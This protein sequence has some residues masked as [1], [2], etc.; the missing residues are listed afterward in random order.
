MGLV[1]RQD[2]TVSVEPSR[3]SPAESAERSAPRPPAGSTATPE[4]LEPTEGISQFIRKVLDQL[5]LSAWLPA[6]MFVGCGALLVQL[7][8]QR[9]LDISAA[10]RALTN[11]PLG[12]LVVGLFGLVVSAIVIQAFS[13]EVIRFLEGYWGVTRLGSG[14]AQIKITG[15]LCQLHKLRARHTRLERRAFALARKVMLEKG[16]DRD[17][18]NI[19]EDGVYK[20][21]LGHYSEEVR[22][23]AYALGWRRFSRPQALGPLDRLLNRLD[24]YP[25]D[26]RVLPTR[27]GNVLR[28]REDE[29]RLDDGDL[30]GLVMR[31]YERIPPRVRIH[32]D[33]FRTRLDMY[34]TLFFVFLLLMFLSLGLVAI[35]VKP[36]LAA[37]FPA[38]FVV[39]AV[40]SYAAAITSARGY[41]AALRA[42]QKS[43]EH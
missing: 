34:C 6:T 20:R 8:G 13:F 32:H 29:L 22:K 25:D 36:L 7:I 3:K 30:E 43:S 41:G 9:D 4:T 40:V 19:L 14:L 27:L 5:S 17:V 42:I 35:S 31:Q 39:L 11:K 16:I 28:A 37:A 23:E 12:I 24:D 38:S 10:V 26:H 1:L 18:I 21:P 33:Q 15:Q 2:V